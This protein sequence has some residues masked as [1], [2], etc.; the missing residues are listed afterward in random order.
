MALFSKVEMQ[1]KI[2]KLIEDTTTLV[3][4][5]NIRKVID[6]FEKNCP[7]ERIFI[8]ESRDLLCDKTFIVFEA[9]KSKLKY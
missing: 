7:K 1:T 5:G 9:T 6:S 2:F 3:E 8:K 4:C